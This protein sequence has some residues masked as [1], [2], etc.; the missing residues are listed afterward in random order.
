MTDSFRTRLLEAA[1][2]ALG[3]AYAPYSEFRVGAALLTDSGDIVPGCNIEN[4]AYS[5][6]I[7]AERVAVAGAV[8]SGA[9]KFR[10]MAVVNDS[11]TTCA[12]CG[13]CRQ[14]LF[15]FAPDAEVIL[16]DGKGGLII[17]TVRELLPLAF[18]R[19]ALSRRLGC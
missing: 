8:A 6:T 1:R 17:S 16:E 5:S 12:P 11:G 4:A 13:T 19:D 3:F 15:E 2:G 10:A 14:V 7:C 9:R 18:G